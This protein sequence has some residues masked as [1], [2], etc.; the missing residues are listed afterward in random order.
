MSGGPSGA[1]SGLRAVSAIPGR[2][3][4]RAVAHGEPEL[5]SVA[6]E[7][8]SW[9]TVT[10]VQMRDRSSSVIVRFPPQHTNEVADGLLQ[11]GVDLQ[12][13]GRPLSED[14]PAAVIAAAGRRA[15]GA[16]AAR[17]RGTDLRLLLPL[18]LGLISLRRAMRGGD[19]L[20]DAPWYV[21]AWYASETF[22]KFHGGRAP[23]GVPVGREEG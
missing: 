10:S 13:I 17:L 8:D 7:L 2:I 16:V 1:A 6:E 23:A 3:R 21:L 5:S 22:W 9:P 14:D 20:A 18:G 4:L 11:L 19:R 12:A 15:N